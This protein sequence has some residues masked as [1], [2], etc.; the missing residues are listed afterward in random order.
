MILYKVELLVK[1]ETGGIQTP[2]YYVES[3]REVRSV[4]RTV[5]PDPNIEITGIYATPD[6]QW[7]AVEVG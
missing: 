5:A 4:I 7:E 3:A 2:T 6:F 1:G